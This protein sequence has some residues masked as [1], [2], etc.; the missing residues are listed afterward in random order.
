MEIVVHILYNKKKNTEYSDYKNSFY[1]KTCGLISNKDL[2]QIVCGLLKP[3][4]L[5]FNF[6]IKFSFHSHN[7]YINHTNSHLLYPYTICH[8]DRV[9]TYYMSKQKKNLK[10][11]K[12]YDLHRS[13][14]T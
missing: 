4:F 13:P 11:L 3:C 14:Y 2:W 7:N 12:I 6:N 9:H 8:I 1:I 5:K 10:Q